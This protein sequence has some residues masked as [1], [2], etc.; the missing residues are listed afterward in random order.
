M[1]PKG[2]ENG[3]PTS[4][5]STNTK[6]GFF[7]SLLGGLRNPDNTPEKKA[8]V[9]AVRAQNNA[10]LQQR[11]AERAAVMQDKLDSGAV[12]V[13]T[14]EEVQTGQTPVVNVAEAQPPQNPEN[15]Q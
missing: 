9:E 12:P 2:S 7:K 3:Q 4:E 11:A 10:A 14:A 1:P 5:Q 13:V 15:S 6:K 8:E